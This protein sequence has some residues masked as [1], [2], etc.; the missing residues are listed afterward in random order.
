MKKRLW[1]L[2][3][4]I[5]MLSLTACGESHEAANTM[6]YSSKVSSAGESKGLSDDTYVTDNYEMATEAAEDYEAEPEELSADSSADSSGSVKDK[7]NKTNKLDT[8]KLIYRCSISLET[9]EFKE[10]ISSF[11]DLI[12]KY[13]G[14]VENENTSTKGGSYGGSYNNGLGVYTATIRVPSENYTAFIND[15]GSIG[16]LNNKSQNVTNVS[17]EYSDLS[18]EMEVLEAERDDY[19]DMLK[20]AKSLE[21]M[22]N[23]ILIRDK[24]TSVN[25]E[26][27]QIKTRLNSIDND[28]AYSYVDM[29]IYE[30]REV[31]EYTED[32]FGT[33]FKREVKQ[34][35]Y[36]FLYGLQNFVIW[37]VANIWGLLIFFGIV[38]LIIFIIRKLIKRGKKKRAERMNL[39]DGMAPQ[40]QKGAPAQ[41]GV[42][43]QGNVAQPGP[44]GAKFQ[45]GASAQQGANVQGAPVQ[46]GVQ[47][48]PGANVQGATAQNPQ[49]AE[50]QSGTNVQGTPAQ[51]NTTV[52]KD[53]KGK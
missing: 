16:T 38:F 47:P 29:Q 5:M 42:Q 2:M 33:R 46:P 48:Q 10:T 41:P 1:I 21:D 45:K 23:V 15:A 6:D 19:M 22:D 13:D 44:Q 3:A 30:V 12:K 43:P 7:E 32:D 37:F 17:Q 51:Q 39:Q 35:W 25:T 27:N 26:I 49:G 8:E 11:Q 34:G 18:V 53:K 20:E 40:F 28:V 52:K 9:K 4:G 24:I 36:N 14:F 31:V 50:P